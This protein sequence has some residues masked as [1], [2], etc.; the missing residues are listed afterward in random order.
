M[1]S[2]KYTA[3]TLGIIL[4][5]VGFFW[6][7]G[8]FFPTRTDMWDKG[9]P[10]DFVEEKIPNFGWRGDKFWLSLDYPGKQ[11]VCLNIYLTSGSPQSLAETVLQSPRA[12]GYE[13]A[14]NID[15]LFQAQSEAA[16][17][18]DLSQDKPYLLNH[19]ADNIVREGKDIFFVGAGEKFLLPTKNIF[20]TYF[21]TLNLPRPS[22]QDSTLTYSNKLIN[23]PEGALLSDGKGVF[24]MSNRKLALIRSPEI[25]DSL[26]YKWEEIRQMSKADQAFTPYL[27][28][29]LI[30]FD[31]AHPNGTILKEGDNLFF[32]WKEKLYS[33]DASEQ[34][35]YFPGTPVVEIKKQ[36]LQSS[37]QANSDKKITCCVNNFDPRLNPPKIY[38]MSNSLYFDLTKIVPKNNIDRVSLQSKIVVNQENILHRLSSL[39]N[40]ILYTSGILK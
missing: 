39:K 33:F 9:Q 8:K 35:K 36:T 13:L 20:T 22:A 37:C 24:V 31:A 23:F 15:S 28:G 21:P 3:I 26:G 38:P 40:Y 7:Y 19:L 10:N 6:F 1:L 2:R 5:I 4:L 34:A 18:E 30:D 17:T 11:D 25:F 32:V 12:A 14:G 27:S 16:V 29:N